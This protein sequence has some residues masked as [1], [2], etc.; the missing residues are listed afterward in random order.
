M[1]KQYGFMSGLS[2]VLQLVTVMEKWTSILDE[3]GVVDVVY[4]DFKKTFD[5]GPHRRLLK[6][7]KSFNIGDILE[8]TFDFLGERKQRVIVNGTTSNQMEVISGMPHRSILGPLCII[9]LSEIIL[10]TEIF[11]NADDT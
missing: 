7:M 1:R 5:T 3:G 2:T 11:L 9:D 8:W 4:C 6:K 10:N